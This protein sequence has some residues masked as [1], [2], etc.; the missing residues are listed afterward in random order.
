MTNEADITA[1]VEISA[2]P[3]VSAPTDVRTHR[4]RRVFSVLLGILTII[5]LIAS[6]V[7]VWARGVLFDSESVAVAADSALHQPETVDS[8]ANYITDQI[9]LAVDVDQ[10]IVG[11]LPPALD[12][13]SPALVGGIRTVVQNRLT[14]LLSREEVRRL[15]TDVIERAHGRL[16]KLLRGDGGV[17]GVSVDNGEVSINL[18]PL[19]SRGLLAIQDL[20]VL[21][22][23]RV[24]VFTA[25]GDPAEQQA[26]LSVAIGRTLPAD[27]GQLVVYRSEKLATAQDSLAAAQ[28][29]LV[30]ARRALWLLLVL[31]VVSFALCIGLAVRRGH[32]VMVLLFASAASMVVVRAI[33]RRV[34]AE[35]PTLVIDPGARAAVRITV[36]ELTSGLLTAVSVLALSAVVAVIA[37]YFSGDS[38]R[39][40]ALRGR[41]GS[42]GAGLGGLLAAHGDVVGIVAFAAAV[43]VI[44][45]AGLSIFSIIVA[46]LLGALGLWAMRSSSEATATTGAS[47][48][49]T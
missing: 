24:P 18:L 48:T 47:S 43:F 16:M 1:G 17:T 41:A 33:V 14:V 35:A 8:L 39:A 12:R 30:I 26:E 15:V 42:A 40:V 7:A 9:M 36:N 5:C 27:F 11:V 46:A 20:G 22:D 28:D 2:Q 13:L 3:A 49:T 44:F 29:A 32:T 25:D 21:A 6:V 45:F 38:K 19:L 10:Y 31:T 37:L 4:V 23:A 34:K